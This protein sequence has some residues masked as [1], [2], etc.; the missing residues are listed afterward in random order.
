VKFFHISDSDNLLKTW[1][2]LGDSERPMRV[3]L[4]IDPTGTSIH[5]VIVS[6][7]ETASVS[8]CWTYSSLIIGDF[9]ARSGDPTGKSDASSANK[10]LLKMRKII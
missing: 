10:W 7:C 5:L 9:T 6:A 3:K 8:G 1:S 2:S 4:G